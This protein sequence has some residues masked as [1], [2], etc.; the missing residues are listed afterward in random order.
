VVRLGQPLAVIAEPQAHLFCSAVSRRMHMR[1]RYSRFSST[2]ERSCRR[3][4]KGVATCHFRNT[5][6]TRTLSLRPRREPWSACGRSIMS[7]ITDPTFVDHAATGAMI[8]ARV[9]AFD[10]DVMNGIP[11][12]DRPRHTWWKRIHQKIRRR[13][14]GEKRNPRIAS[15]KKPGYRSSSQEAA[16][17]KTSF[18]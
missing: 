9:V 15:R 8:A 5:S 17:L 18:K 11:M 12:T 1:Q 14:N 16:G 10:R 3:K 6:R 13:R 7:L 2:F 4:H